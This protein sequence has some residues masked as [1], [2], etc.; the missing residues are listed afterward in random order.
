MRA[1]AYKVVS[2]GNSLATHDADNRSELHQRAPNNPQSSP[3]NN[4]PTIARKSC[5]MAA[6]P[7]KPFIGADHKGKPAPLLAFRAIP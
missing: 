3:Q 6:T 7:L 1:P 2:F 5:R 4:Q